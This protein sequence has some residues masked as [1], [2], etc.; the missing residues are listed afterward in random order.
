[1]IKKHDIPIYNNRFMIEDGLFVLRTDDVDK[2]GSPDVYKKMG[3]F[4]IVEL[5]S[6]PIGIKT[7]V[8]RDIKSLNLGYYSGQVKVKFNDITQAEY[9]ISRYP[10]VDLI[11][12][13][14][15]INVAIVSVS[16]LQNASEFIRIIKKNPNVSTASIDIIMTRRRGI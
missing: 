12:V 13:Y 1:M 3:P 7:T 4:S 8:V 16:Q 6:A 14:E 9:V 5:D 10:N 11:K 15:H 2:Y